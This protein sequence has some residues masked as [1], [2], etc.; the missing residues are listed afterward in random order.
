[1][2]MKPPIRWHL[3][4]LTFPSVGEIKIPSLNLN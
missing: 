3:A 2:G 4:P 1:M